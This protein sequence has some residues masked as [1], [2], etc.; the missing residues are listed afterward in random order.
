MPRTTDRIPVHTYEI[1]LCAIS[2]LSVSLGHGQVDIMGYD[3]M[4]KTDATTKAGALGNVFT[5][6]GAPRYAQHEL[7][8][9]PYLSRIVKL[10]VPQ[11]SGLTNG[12]TTLYS[13]QPKPISEP[14]ELK[15][16]KQL[17]LPI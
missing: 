10:S 8:R 14:K 1:D 11:Q 9:E 3:R 6:I 13:K 4:Q 5:R 17:P 12:T 15:T 7:S 2:D 16:S